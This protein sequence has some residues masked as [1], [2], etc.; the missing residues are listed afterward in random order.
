MPVPSDI[1]ALS[2]TAASNSPAGSETPSSID[3]YLRSHASFIAQLRAVIGGATNPNI[4]T[5]TGTAAAADLTT[6][7]LDKTAG[8]VLKVGDFGVGT[9][10]ATTNLNTLTGTGLF[11]CLE[12][13]GTPGASFLGWWVFQMDSGIWKNQTAWQQGNPMAQYV[14]SSIDGTTWGDWSRAVFADS[15]TFT[16]TPSGPTAAPGTNTTQFATTAFVLANAQTTNVDQLC[17][18]W[19]NFNGTGTVVIRDSYNVSSITDNGTGAYTVNFTAPMATVNYSV[20][21]TASGSADSAGT[22]R[23]LFP[24]AATFATSSV[25]VRVSSGGGTA[26][27]ES[28]ISVT[29]HGGN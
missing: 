10:I 8:R 12:V 13:T 5:A 27:D 17:T 20:S 1:T 6:S 15:P 19:V 29:I 25:K 21:G 4:P 26:N 11:S 9:P 23:I 22:E 28:V 7:A 2:T 16:G 14:R 3:D 24:I 18:A